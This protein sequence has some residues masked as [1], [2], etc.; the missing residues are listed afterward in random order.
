MK[1]VRTL[2][3]LLAAAALLATT[4]S[5]AHIAIGSGPGLADTTQ[6]V[7]FGVGHG[8]DGADTLRVTIDIPE[9]VV[10]VRPE[11]SELGPASIVTNDAG[12]VTA[13]SW[14]KPIESLLPADTNYYELTLRLKVPN[15]PFSTL[16]FPTHQVCQDS[17]G[18]MTTV[19]WVSTTEGGS[20]EP[21]PALNIV[22]KRFPGWNKFVVGTAIHELSAFFSDALIVWRDSA[23]Y[24]VN[25]ATADLIAAT[26]GVTPLTSVDSGDEIWVKY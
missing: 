17:D 23:A 25:P 21:A 7:V 8:C 9:A 5:K 11:D 13:V 14:E 22:P 16:Y 1:S 10:S 19:D 24:S 26:S 20:E 15:Q 4:L 6:K 2:S 3:S 12:L 18:L